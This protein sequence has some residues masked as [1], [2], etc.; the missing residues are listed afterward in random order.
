MTGHHYTSLFVMGPHH[1]TSQLLPGPGSRV[2]SAKLRC[3]GVCSRSTLRYCWSFRIL[4][5]CLTARCSYPPPLNAPPLL[6]GHPGASTAGQLFTAPDEADLHAAAESLFECLKAEA[7]AECAQERLQTEAE[8]SAMHTRMK[9]CMMETRRRSEEEVQVLP[10][11]P[12]LLDTVYWTTV[13]ITLD[14]L[15]IDRPLATPL[16]TP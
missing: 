1:T 3:C 4:Q 7:A 8:R 9:T 11:C 13:C 5:P 14:T 6:A 16:E 2:P 15:R 12:L 10:H